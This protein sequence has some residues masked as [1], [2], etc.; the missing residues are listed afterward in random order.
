MQKTMAASDIE[1]DNALEAVE[2]VRGAL[3]KQ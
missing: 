2:S 1:V 3:M